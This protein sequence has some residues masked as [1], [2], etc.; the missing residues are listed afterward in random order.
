M[1]PALKGAEKI[2]RASQPIIVF[3]AHQEALKP[4]EY[5]TSLGYQ[6][7]YGFE[8]VKRWYQEVRMAMRRGNKFKPISY[9]D[10]Y[11]HCL[12]DGA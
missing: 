5:L 12:P 4:Y 11:G 8:K 1:K 9:P 10:G 2:I 3:E 6:H 7:F